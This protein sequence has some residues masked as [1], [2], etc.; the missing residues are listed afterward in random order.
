M[1]NN[2]TKVTGITP[3]GS[4][5][6]NTSY[7]PAYAVDGS[8]S[9]YWRPA[10]ADTERSLVFALGTARAVERVNL[11]LDTTFAPSRCVISGSNDGSAYTELAAFTPAQQTG[12]QTLSFS[13]ETAYSYYKIAFPTLYSSYLYLYEIELLYTITW[14]IAD[15]EKIALQ[16]TEEITSGVS[17]IIGYAY[18][19]LTDAVVTTLNQYSTSYPASC[20]TDCDAST[21]TYWYGTTAVNWIMLQFGRARVATG[22]RWYIASSSYYPLTFIIS[23]SNDGTTWTQF[24][25]TF[26]GTG[27]TG[28]QEFTFTNSTGYKNYRINTLTA[29]SSR[30]YISELQLLIE[31]GNEK[32]FTVSGHQYDMQPDGTLIEGS[33]QVE[34]V[35]A[36]LGNDHAILLTMQPLKRFHNVEGSL[37]VSYDSTIGNLAGAGGPVESFSVSFTPDALVQKPNPHD[38]EHIEIAGISVTAPLIRIYYSNY[39]TGEER[40]EITSVTAAGVL[41]HINDL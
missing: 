6:Y 28:W 25:G 7:I 8:T 18:R 34:G 21:S 27:V 36:Y 9:T 10:S 1:S 29:S 33:Y 4:S 38:P 24:G 13:N 23:G 35:S 3:T 14:T 22:F 31:Y 26:T 39:Q 19:Q 32:A 40:I 12:W 17:N 41:T 11:Y 2:H 30:L 37:A 5:Q 20:L 15:G 16:F